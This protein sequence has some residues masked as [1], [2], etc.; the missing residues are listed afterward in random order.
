MMSEDGYVE[1]YMEEPKPNEAAGEAAFASA[2]GKDDQGVVTTSFSAAASVSYKQ[3]IMLARF[4]SMLLFSISMLF[5][6][7][8]SVFP[9]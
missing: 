2:S 1:P 3:A 6:A 5:L 9:H 7:I 4:Y 8:F